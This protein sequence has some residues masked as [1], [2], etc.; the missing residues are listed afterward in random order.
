MQQEKGLINK[1]GELVVK[2]ERT[3]SQHQNLYDAL[4]KVKGMLTE[5][6]HVPKE[7][8]EETKQKI[9]HFKGRENEKRIENK[10]RKSFRKFDRK[11]VE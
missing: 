2:S 4:D 3:R 7:T 10:K 8:S 6:C 1:N 5:A 9:V 11:N